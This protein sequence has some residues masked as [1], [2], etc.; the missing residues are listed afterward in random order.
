M[1]FAYLLPQS[2]RRLLPL[3]TRGLLT[4]RVL[5]LSAHELVLDME[6]QRGRSYFRP[7]LF[8]A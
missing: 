6:C 3:L 8:S 2:A 5:D 1:K 7:N 4:P